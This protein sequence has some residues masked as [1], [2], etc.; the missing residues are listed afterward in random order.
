MTEKEFIEVLNALF[1]TSSGA[2][3]LFLEAF[4][5]GKCQ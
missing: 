1:R 4:E 3:S 2:E 5:E